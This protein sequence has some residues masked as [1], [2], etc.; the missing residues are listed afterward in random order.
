MV[1]A[2]A[3]VI[4]GCPFG[5]F[6][7]NDGMPT[8]VAGGGSRQSFDCIGTIDGASSTQ[9][10]RFLR[11]TSYVPPANVLRLAGWVRFGPKFVLPES[12]KKWQFVH[13]Y[14]VAVRSLISPSHGWAGPSC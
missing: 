12:L 3:R 5:V 2:S 8:Q 11:F 14:F 10:T 6:F 7:V 1:S 13:W 9:S 4:T